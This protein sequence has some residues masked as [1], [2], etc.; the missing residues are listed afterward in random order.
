M[1]SHTVV[2]N[3]AALSAHGMCKTRAS[4]TAAYSKKSGPPQLPPMR[5]PRPLVPPDDHGIWRAQWVRC[6]VT[7]ISAATIG[8]MGAS[9]MSNPGNR[10]HF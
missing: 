6:Q 2:I 3:P 5:P 9:N 4:H 7:Q 8:W 1:Q 10:C